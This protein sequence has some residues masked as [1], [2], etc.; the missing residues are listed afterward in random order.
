MLKLNVNVVIVI[1]VKPTTHFACLRRVAINERSVY[2][3]FISANATASNII[4]HH[5][6]VEFNINLSARVL[7]ITSVW[8]E[9]R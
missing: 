9:P 3:H 2:F 8:A 1:V 7:D 5:G 4:I 6:V